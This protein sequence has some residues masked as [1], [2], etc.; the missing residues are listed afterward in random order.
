MS[1]LLSFAGFELRYHLRRP[2]TYVFMAAMFF[3]G[4]LYAVSDAVNVSGV[5][6]R[7]VINSPFILTQVISILSLAGLIFTSAISGTAIL[8]DFEMKTHELLFTT[9]LGKPSFVLGRFLGA[10]IVTVLVLSCVAL[11]I[12]AAMYWPWTAADR[13]GPGGL[14][15][16]LWPLLVYVVPNTLL[17]CALFFAVGIVT[18]SFIAVYVQGIVLFMGWQIAANLLSDID[19]EA[20]A[21][22]L[23]PFGIIATNTIQRTWSV[24]EKNT[25][26][27]PLSGLLLQNRLLWVAG[28]LLVLGLAFWRFRMQAFTNS[29]GARRRRAAAGDADV[30]PRITD[31]NLPRAAPRPGGPGLAGLRS[32]VGLYFR[33]ITRDRAFYAI[34]AVGMANTIIN[35]FYADVLFGT[36][37][38]PV[39][40]AMIEIISSFQ[41]F[42]LIL[43][44]LYAG[45]LVWRERSLRCD[46]IQGA[47]PVS[48]TQ[49]F[50]AKIISLVLVHAL[51]LAMLIGVGVATQALRGYFNFELDVYFGFLYGFFL[52]DLILVTLLAFFLHVLVDQKFLGNALVVVYYIYTIVSSALGLE[53]RLYN[54]SQA[55]TPTYSAMNGY[56]PNVDMFFWLIAYYFAFAMVLMALARLLLVRGNV[57]GWRARLRVARGRLG[58]AWFAF[59]G[60]ALVAWLGLGGFIFYNTNVLNTYRTSDAGEA[61]QAEYERGYKQYE[62]LPQPRITAVAVA[63]QLY[64]ERGHMAAKGSYTLVNRHEVAIERV[65]V[66]TRDVLTIHE[67]AFDRASELEHEDPRLRYQIYR[68]AEPLRPGETMTLRFDL[69]YDRVGFPN[70]GRLTAFVANG[71]FFNNTDVFPGI[72]YTAQGELADDDKRKEQGLPP[73][74]RMPS[75]DDEDA[76]KNT[77]IASD[78]DWIDFSSSVCTAPDQIALAP[79]YLEREWEQDGRRCFAY[80]MDAKI[81]PFYSF[82]S[83]RYEVLRDRWNDV[84]IEI[85]YQ[86]GHEYNLARMVEGVKKSL[87]YYTTNFSPYQHRQVRILE[88]PRYARFAQAFPNT[89][90]FSESIGFIARV[91]PNSPTDLDYPFYVTAHEVAHQWWAHQVIGANVQGSTMLSESLSQ[92][93]AL[94]VMEK[95]VGRDKMKRFLAYELQSYLRGRGNER[96][97]ELPLMLVEDQPY[98]HYNKGSLVLYALRDYIGEDT[99]NSALRRY[100]QQVA[101][102]QPPFTTSKDLIK[103]LREVTPPEHAHLIVDMFE[104]ITLF[105]NRVVSASVREKDGKYVVSVEL[106]ARKLRSDEQGV[107]AEVPLADDIEVGVFAEPAPG[108][109]LGVPLYIKRHRFDQAT[110]TLELVVDQPPRRVGIDPYNKLIDRNPRDNLS[111]L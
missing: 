34:V 9:R 7:I 52:P 15:H 48:T 91:D 103:I 19:N 92:Y 18:R 39:T 17:A 14:V 5:G 78:A 45:E 94:M 55:P 81:L 71:T 83:A 104:T 86:P 85:Y 28:G 75:I 11:G 46:Q 56:G 77:Y 35:A 42:F 57:A 32:L 100:V 69:A 76:R 106:A 87:D 97:K 51:L 10:Y 37:I 24:V 99:L 58:P 53:H 54:Y 90:P 89:I 44:A 108:D 20:R 88:F 13:I 68:L 74:E 47:T 8:R 26:D 61:L 79:G 30:A 12:G 67:L 49:V 21:A 102:Q 33:D 80:K 105:E 110:T 3:F 111:P 82:M 109:E 27:I 66:R 50:V 98:I 25:L 70:A 2:L 59:A 23:D 43:I 72:G 84:N 101:F 31:L 1:Q 16:Y 22:L 95:E 96:K 73:R 41:L 63:A 62:E 65:H 38:Y 29:R 36:T 93:S 6:G 4:F 40:Y 60:L 107:E 64:P